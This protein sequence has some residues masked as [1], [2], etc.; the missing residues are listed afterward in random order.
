MVRPKPLPTGDRSNYLG[1]SDAAAIL[2]LSPWRSKMQVYLEKNGLAEEIDNKKRAVFARGHRFEPVVIGMLCDELTAQGHEVRVMARNRRYV[3]NEHPF[4]GSEIDVELLVDG[5][6]VNGEAKTVSPFAAKLWGAPDS[7]DVPLYYQA[8]CMHAL[9]VYPRRRTVIGAMVGLDDFRVR[10]IER[11]DDLIQI[12]TAKE[13]EFWQDVQAG[14]MPAPTTAGDVA[15]LYQ[16]RGEAVEITADAALAVEKL[17]QIKQQQAALDAEREQ[18]ELK[19]QLQMRDAA[20]ALDS[21]G[22]TLATWRQNKERQTTDW[23]AVAQALGASPALIEQHTRTEPGARVFRL[24]K[25]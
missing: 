10:W 7:N 2:G 15:W 5:E 22:R 8:Q 9:S 20:T 21:T 14:R 19:I 18:L 17:R 4:I 24:T 23:Q 25:G 11:D 12:I 6:E 16:D 13:V 3:H 1:S